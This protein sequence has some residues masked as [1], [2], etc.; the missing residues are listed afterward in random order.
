MPD[1]RIRQS[2][3]L[4]RAHNVECDAVVVVDPV[5]VFYLSG[6]VSSNAAILLEDSGVTVIT[7]GRYVDG[8]RSSGLDCRIEERRDVLQAVEELTVDKLTAID[9]AAIT[10]QDL[11]SLSQTRFRNTGNLCMP[12][13]MIKDVEERDLIAQACAITAEAMME[14]FAGIKIGDTEKEIAR[15]FEIAI[16]DKG[17]DARAFDTIVASGSH[18]AVP[19]HRPTDRTVR[20]GDLVLIDAGAR[21]DGYHADMTR[22]AVIGAAADWQR[23]LHTAVHTTQALGRQSAHPDDTSLDARMRDEL[24]QSIGLEIPHGTGHGIGLQIHE[25]PLMTAT[26][27]YSIPRDVVFTIEPGG[28]LADRGGVRIE[29]TGVMTKAGFQV[30]TEA[31]REL[32]T[33]D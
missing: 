33:I 8:V 16:L 2:R 12:D 27:T 18:S 15:R 7:D 3:V 26:A 24:R 30:L 6:I 19:H 10:A 25:P 22:T 28:Y 14:T 5:D 9:F 21:I 13:R 32:I 17:A 31:T 11:E 4:D 20:R 1:Y 23:D 29:D